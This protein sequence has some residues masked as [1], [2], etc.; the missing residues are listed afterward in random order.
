MF[1][2]ENMNDSLQMRNS[3]MKAHKMPAIDC[4]A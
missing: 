2:G 3:K 1:S 4:S